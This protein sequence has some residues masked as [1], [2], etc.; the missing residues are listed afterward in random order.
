MPTMLPAN[1]WIRDLSDMK[2][3]TYF[4]VGTI[5]LVVGPLQ[6]TE[7]GKWLAF[8]GGL[9]AAVHGLLKMDKND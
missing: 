1:V 3:D 5:W 4:I 2:P 8:F 7:T 9:C 6:P